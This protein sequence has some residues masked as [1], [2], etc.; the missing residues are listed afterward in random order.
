[1]GLGFGEEGFGGSHLGDGFGAGFVGAE[2]APNPLMASKRSTRRADIFLMVDLGLETVRG[3]CE[4][5]E[6]VIE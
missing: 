5:T 1:M 6:S 2:S 4:V 3:A